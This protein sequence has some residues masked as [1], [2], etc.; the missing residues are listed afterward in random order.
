MPR[1]EDQERR[2]LPA[3]PEDCVPAGHRLLWS[4]PLGT[5]AG[6]LWMGRC[7]PGSFASQHLDVRQKHFLPSR[8]EKEGKSQSHWGLVLQSF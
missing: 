8:F 5:G 3:A 6:P 7:G 1:P 2:R 4:G